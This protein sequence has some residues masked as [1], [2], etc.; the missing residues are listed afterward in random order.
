[1]AIAISRRNFLTGLPSLPLALA[2]TASAAAL[3]VYPEEIAV[4]K[5]GIVV[6]TDKSVVISHCYVECKETGIVVNAKEGGNMLMSNMVYAAN[7]KT[8]IMA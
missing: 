5:D 4:G 6:N 8:G 1:M 2:G 7:C 3:S